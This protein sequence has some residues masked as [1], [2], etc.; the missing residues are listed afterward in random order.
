MVDYII[1]ATA[2]GGTVRAFVATTTNMV[3][4]A[5]IT[6]GL[7]SVA[8]A[9]LGRT[10][11]A[12]A[13]MSKELKGEK[14]TVTL[15]IKG[16][17]PL[18]GIVTVTDANSNVR[19]YVNNPKVYLPLNEEGKLDVANA[20]GSHGYLNVIKDFGLKEPY[21]GFVNL[22]SG[23]IAEDLTYYFAHS[24]QVPSAVSLGVLVDADESVM[25]AGGFIIQLM[26]GAGDDI[27]DY[28]ESTI[29]CIP[30]IT[31]MLSYGEIP[32]TILEIIF[33][34]K[35]LKILEKTAINYVCNCSREKMERNLISLG[36]KEIQ[37]IIDEQGTAELVCHFC[38]T[39]YRFN[40][41][42][43]KALVKEISK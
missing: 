14:D 43:L 3:E 35:D 12:A 13:L 33:G 2:A 32:E 11:T 41:S 28:I 10:L 5:R 38:N 17:G 22:V 34:E 18:G 9:A 42:E 23:E 25:Y 31:E 7:S 39:E 4:S 30:S 40:E 29:R 21:I 16:D 1:R 15:Q 26:P 8:S 6:H 20:V 27:I 36:V 24:E 19:G 37:S